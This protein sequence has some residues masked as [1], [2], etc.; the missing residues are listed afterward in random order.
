MAT[1]PLSEKP[2]APMER[3]E[4]PH[5]VK[6]A[7]TLGGEPRVLDARLS[8]LQIFEMFQAGMT[9][10]EIIGDFQFLTP[11][12]I[13]DAVSYA[14]DHPDEMQ[15][16]RERHDIRNIMRDLDWV[17]V[18]TRLISRRRLNLENV[19]QETPVYTWETLPRDE[20]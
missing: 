1:T 8:V 13:Y 17:M 12:H 20:D 14:H 19:P 6:S 5:V 3:T 16:H 4:H 2:R 9:A 10:E 7:D 18:G 15:F 11:A